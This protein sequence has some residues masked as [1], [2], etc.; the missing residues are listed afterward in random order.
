NTGWFDP[1]R[2]L[3]TLGVSAT[4][5]ISGSDGYFNALGVGV[6]NPQ[7]RMEVGA[8]DNRV[9]IGTDGMMGYYYA[10]QPNPRWELRSDGT[11]NFHE[12][13]IFTPGSSDRRHGAA[14]VYRGHSSGMTLQTGNDSYLVERVMIAHGAD[15]RVG[16]STTNPL[17]MLDVRG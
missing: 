8:P 9:R 16:I 3:V 4:G 17:A 15:T 12:A 11:P 1:Q 10:N 6:T 2:G 13:L 7:G 5:P 14:V